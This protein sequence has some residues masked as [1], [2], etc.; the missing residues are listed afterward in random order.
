MRTY[1]YFSRRVV[2]QFP[3]RWTI[4][5]SRVLAYVNMIESE[6]SAGFGAR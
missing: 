4:T 6:K 1:E 2:A 3:E 5:R